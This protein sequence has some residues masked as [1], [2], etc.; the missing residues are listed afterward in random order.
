MA[1]REDPVAATEK[2][3]SHLVESILNWLR[4]A[5]L[6]LVCVLWICL[7]YCHS[8]MTAFLAIPE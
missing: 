5:V 6:V 3:A 8:L 2:A 4:I 1:G 7:I